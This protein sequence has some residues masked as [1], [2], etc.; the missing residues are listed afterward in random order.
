MTNEILKDEERSALKVLARHS[1][2]CA[3]E[4]LL[5]DGLSSGQLAGLVI[6]GFGTM[7]PMVTLTGERETVAVSMQITEAGRAALAE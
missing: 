2:G 7:H 1:G 3:E 5:A 4:V 6:D